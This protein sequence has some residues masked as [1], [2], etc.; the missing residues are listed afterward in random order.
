MLYRL[1][2]TNLTPYAA[3]LAVLLVLQVIGTLASLYLPSLNGQII[4]EGVAVGDT[5]FILRTGAV[6]LVVSLVQVLATIGAELRMADTPTPEGIVAAASS[7]D[8]R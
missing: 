6:M 4:D 5:A 7:S 3:P 1:V 2:R 8:A